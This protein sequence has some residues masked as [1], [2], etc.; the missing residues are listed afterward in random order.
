MNQTLTPA[1]LA[2]LILSVAAPS[3]KKDRD[4]AI[5]VHKSTLMDNISMSE[6]KQMFLAD[7][8][9]WSDGKRVV[10]VGKEVGQPEHDAVLKIVYGMSEGDF[11]RYFIQAGFTGKTQTPPKLLGSA[12]AVRGTVAATPGA[13]GYMRATEVDDSVKVL[14]VDGFA[15]GDAGYRI[16][17]E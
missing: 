15:P 16:R 4:V 13:V 2:G 11:K 10:L 14:K 9:R 7:K 8:A 6:L 5:V 17:V 12:S 1:L 3:G